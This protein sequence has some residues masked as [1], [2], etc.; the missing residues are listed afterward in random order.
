MY[1]FCPIC[2]KPGINRERRINGN[3]R[4]ENGH[5]YPS[6]DS[7]NNK[8][9]NL[10]NIQCPVCG[11]YCLGKGGVECIDKSRFLEIKCTKTQE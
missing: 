10:D 11:Y 7:L 3:D 9:D 4:C 8:P 6:K 1:G 5:T 2:G